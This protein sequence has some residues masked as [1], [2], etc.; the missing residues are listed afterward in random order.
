ML[1]LDKAILKEVRSSSKMYTE[2]LKSGSA[3]SFSIKVS[4]TEN[5][6]VNSISKN[7]DEYSDVGICI[8][9]YVIH[10]NSFGG[11]NELIDKNYL[12]DTIFNYT[13]ISEMFSG[14]RDFRNDDEFENLNPQ[15]VYEYDGIGKKKRELS[16]TEKIKSMADLRND[17][18]K[19][20]EYQKELVKTIGDKA[21]AVAYN[22][23]MAYKSYEFDQ[24]KTNY[25]RFKNS[26]CFQKLG[27]DPMKALKDSIGLEIDYH[28]CDK[29]IKQNMKNKYS[30]IIVSLLIVLSLGI[31][32]YRFFTN[33]NK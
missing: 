4:T 20:A 7:D 19:R 11:K 12:L 28:A 25:D 14:I 18:N 30:I 22:P 5:S 32:G 33:R 15:G 26:P 9:E 24:Y 17:Y 2:T 3:N 27:F 29:E 31:V 23:Y 8:E 16:K 1:N 13:T 10:Y 21:E 6:N